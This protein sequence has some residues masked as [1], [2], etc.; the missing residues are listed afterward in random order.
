MPFRDRLDTALARLRSRSPLVP[1]IGSSSSEA[2]GERESEASEES[3]EG[4]HWED[5]IEH[6]E[7]EQS[8]EYE[9]GVLQEKFLEEGFPF[10]HLM[11]VVAVPPPTL[12]PIPTIATAST[13]A[14]GLWEGEL[15]FSTA[16]G[17]T[18]ASTIPAPP[19]ARTPP[20]A[21][22]LSDHP[23]PSPLLRDLHNWIGEGESG[24]AVSGR[25]NGSNGIV[26]QP[27]RH[28][29]TNNSNL[30]NTGAIIPNSNIVN[31][32]N[33]ASIGNNN[34]A[35]RAAS[36]ST[37]TT[38]TS[39]V[40]PSSVAG[41]FAG[42][43]AFGGPSEVSAPSQ[44]AYQGS[45]IF[46]GNSGRSGADNL[47]LRL[48]GEVGRDGLPM[49]GGFLLLDSLFCMCRALCSLQS[50]LCHVVD[51]P[52][53]Q[54]QRHTW[55]A[56]PLEV[57][58]ATGSSS[59]LR[60]R[61]SVSPPPRLQARLRTPPD[62]RL[63]MLTRPS[64]PLGE[65]R[66]W[67]PLPRP[68]ARTQQ[69]DSQSTP[70]HVQLA[71]LAAMV[72]RSS[73]R[74]GERRSWSP[75]SR[76]PVEPYDPRSTPPHIQLAALAAIVTRSSSRSSER[77]SWWPS[78]P[79][80]F[81]AQSPASVSWYHNSDTN[82]NAATSNNDPN[83][84]DS[85]TTT[86]TAINANNNTS[87]A[88]P[89][90]GDTNF[91]RDFAAWFNPVQNELPR[92]H[93][94]EEAEEDEGS[95]E[96]DD[97][98][99]EDEDER[100]RRL[101]ANIL[102]TG[103]LPGPEEFSA[104]FSSSLSGAVGETQ[105][106]NQNQESNQNQ[107]ENS[108]RD[109][110]PRGTTA[111]S[112][113]SRSYQRS[114]RPGSSN[115]LVTENAAEVRRRADRAQAE[116]WASGRRRDPPARSP[117]PHL[118]GILTAEGENQLR[119][120]PWGAELLERIGATEQNRSQSRSPPDQRRAQP[121]PIAVDPVMAMDVSEDPPRRN[122]AA[123]RMA[124]SGHM[125]T[126]EDW[127]A[128]PPVYI[129]RSPP[130]RTPILDF[131][132]RPNYFPRRE[133][134]TPTDPPSL[135][136]P[137]LGGSFDSESQMA[138]SNPDTQ[139][140]YPDRSYLSGS[141]RHHQRSHP[142]TPLITPQ[143]P[144]PP[145]LTGLSS[146]RNNDRD[147]NN[148]HA[149][150][151]PQPTFIEQRI[152]FVSTYEERERARSIIAEARRRGI[153]DRR[154]A[155]EDDSDDDNR[156]VPHDVVERMRR[157]LHSMRSMPRPPQ[158]P[159]ET[160]SSRPTVPSN[161]FSS[162]DYL[163]SV[164]SS[165]A[166]NGSGAARTQRETTSPGHT[167]PQPP[168][169]SPSFTLDTL[170]PS[171][172]APGPIRNTMQQLVDEHERDR[173]RGTAP[174]TS[175]SIPI[176]SQPSSFTTQLAHQLGQISNVVPHFRRMP[177]YRPPN[178]LPPSIPPLSFD[179]GNNAGG[180]AGGTDMDVVDMGF[181]PSSA[182]PPS[183]PAI[184]VNT[185]ENPNT[186]RTRRFSTY[187]R[188]LGTSIPISSSPEDRSNNA[189]R[190]RMSG[191]ESVYARRRFLPDMDLLTAPPSGTANPN[192]SR[193][194]NLHNTASPEMHRYIH[195]QVRMADALSGTRP[196]V[197]RPSAAGTP[198]TGTSTLSANANNATP[199]DSN[200]PLGPYTSSEVGR[201]RLLQRHNPDRMRQRERERE[202]TSGN[203]NSSSFRSGP[204]SP[205]TA[206]AIA[207]RLAV[208]QQNER[209]DR[210]ERL[211]SL[212]SHLARSRRGRFG[213]TAA[214]ANNS[215]ND[216]DAGPR[217]SSGAFSS[218]SNVPPQHQHPF[219]LQNFEY[220]HTLQAETAGWAGPSGDGPG[221]A[222]ARRGRG[223]RARMLG[224]YMV[225]SNSLLFFSSIAFRFG[226][227]I[228]TQPPFLFYPKQRDEDF[229]ESYESLISLAAALGEA[230]PRGAPSE[231]V[232]K[233]EKGKYKDW[234]TEE[235]DVRC[236]ICLDD[237]WFFLVLN[238]R[239]FTD[240]EWIVRTR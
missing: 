136:P 26:G 224:D 8:E 209:R 214:G 174:S 188:G 32:S 110:S 148:S 1:G 169:A 36:P 103:R 72:T 35:A 217:S 230:K 40:R 51:P 49:F 153:E 111:R 86:T 67:S 208:V 226:Y 71:A 57:P 211:L 145:P 225:S 81:R 34:T 97:D 14:Q 23:L 140:F 28:T 65:R 131:W 88:A 238:R 181:S 127:L 195:A 132:E 227:K 236:P 64:S 122:S 84:N 3:G 45:S 47:R 189:G 152:P 168:L 39:T 102:S 221:G 70:P 234:K 178:P 114:M 75:P 85:T 192:G 223:G 228:L 172:F 18:T 196:T 44:S 37:S 144:P 185:T 21:M 143:L 99:M 126:F 194:S 92:S 240:D 160:S 215:S 212:Q 9:Q 112:N 197:S 157:T 13:S 94:S 154:R 95:E 11:N 183:R 113:P 121:P 54:Q 77:R 203:A 166:G 38:S 104:G 180:R 12:P 219:T 30:N 206:A 83:S 55:G 165:G 115:S 53:E 170:N 106:Q 33:I 56:S 87:A 133:T 117:W 158:P 213:G 176:T 232:E 63:G 207:A 167:L 216:T 171:S 142:W 128:T 233:M 43:A 130:P 202:P 237:V 91:E 151:P 116:E 98:D 135:P 59:R 137:D 22:G 173:L 105:N 89:A 46:G 231:V 31:T 120:S 134:A 218:A 201:R 200:T 60:E 109:S 107:P 7:E 175:T 79:P 125:P 90:S 2:S 124:S 147:G 186:S 190:E 25:P 191:R 118:Q 155:N 100:D 41:G 159:V 139:A 163:D 76:F 193:A 50:L 19:R 52:Y 20:T 17:D 204:P 6:E 129:P 48:P 74:S 161:P 69:Y 182:A 141:L 29:I 199:L 229:D 119:D 239:R 138:S 149:A 93:E 15:L 5:T 164:W 184:P 80:N 73:S 68:P 222:G 187:A 42:F 123:G 198:G 4:D 210:D 101:R 24:P 78:S 235:S 16:Q 205:P 179:G 220:W 108:N 82:N 62:E 96:D 66:S 162:N 58:A 146:D 150:P 27:E 61:R 177:L 156:S 10:D